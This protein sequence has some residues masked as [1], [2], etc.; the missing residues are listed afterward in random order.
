MNKE[1]LT[2]ADVT[3]IDARRGELIHSKDIVKL[4]GKATRLGQARGEILV[5]I[6]VLRELVNTY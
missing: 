3:S 5:V 6:E 2:H 1:A 4:R